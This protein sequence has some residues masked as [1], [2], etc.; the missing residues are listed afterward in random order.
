MKRGGSCHESAYPGEECK[1]QKAVFGRPFK[2]DSFESVGR[3]WFA[4]FSQ[5]WAEGHAETIITRL[6]KFVFP[7][8]GK[9]A[10]DSITAPDV[11]TV[12]RRIEVRG[13]LETARRDRAICS[14]V[15]PYAIATGKAERDP[16]ADLTSA[17][18]AI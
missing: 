8:I 2:D 12:L 1:Q 16:A 5:K 4:K 10:V 9:Q 6:E 15:F 14:Q 3:K 17:N 13:T 18:G 11:L 7:Y